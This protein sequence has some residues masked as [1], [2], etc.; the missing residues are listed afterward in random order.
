MHVLACSVSALRWLTT[1]WAA[2][3]ALQDV[4]E[5]HWSYQL[6]D[7]AARGQI[8]KERVEDDVQG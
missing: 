4:C 7:A 2:V 5:A 8:C 3:Q 6:C 1:A